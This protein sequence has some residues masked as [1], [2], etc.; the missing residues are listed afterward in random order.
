[1]I[2]VIIPTNRCDAWLRDSILSTLNSR[3]DVYFEVLVIGNNFAQTDEVLWNELQSELGHRVRFLLLKSVSLVDALNFGVDAAEFNYIARLDSDDVMDSNR[4]QTQFDFLET[5]HEVAVVGS[6]VNLIGLKSE[7][8]GV[9]LFP[10][11]N[12]TILACFRFGNCVAHPSV[13]FRRDVFNSVGRYSNDFTHAEDFDLFTRIAREYQIHNLPQ[14]L[15]SYRI[16]P[17]Q[18]SSKNILAQWD[19]STHIIRREFIHY[20]GRLNFKFQIQK[21]ILD[22][23]YRSTID[24]RRVLSRLFL[25]FPSL[26]LGL[27]LH[28]SST[29][30]YLI[31]ALRNLTRK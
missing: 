27:L 18:I 12:S 21:Q 6:S 28:S 10:E 23:R 24:N 29:L 17:E 1:M 11:M 30:P 3:C 2:S 14:A 4:L 19:I 31:Q 9:R 25:N 20:H 7:P 13:M 26:F 5:N 8:L 15:T 16:F 22:G